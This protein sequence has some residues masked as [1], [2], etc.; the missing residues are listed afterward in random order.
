MRIAR[1]E[2]HDAGGN[3]PP[4]GRIV[5]AAAATANSDQ[6]SHQSIN[7]LDGEAGVEAR[8]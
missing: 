5:S 7:H 1:R 2:L 8:F 6:I 3:G 4:S